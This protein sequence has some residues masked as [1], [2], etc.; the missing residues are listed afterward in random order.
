MQNHMVSVCPVPKI[1]CPLPLR[2]AGAFLLC[3]SAVSLAIRNNKT[4]Q[5]MHN[6]LLR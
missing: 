3:V 4:Q 2:M 5:Y 6:I 1:G